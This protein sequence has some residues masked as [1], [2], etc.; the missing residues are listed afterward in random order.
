MLSSRVHCIWLIPHFLYFLP[1]GTMTSFPSS[2]LRL[3][4]SVLSRRTAIKSFGAGVAGLT[5]Y[6]ALPQRWEHP[7]IEQIILPVHAQTSGFTLS[8]PCEVSLLAGTTES[9]TVRIR[10]E[11]FVAPPTGSLAT[12]IEAV[13]QGKGEPTSLETTTAADG[14]FSGE[15]L[16]IGG[17]GITAVSVTT[18]VQGA[19]GQ[20]QC[21]LSVN[22][23][24]PEPKPPEPLVTMRDEQSILTCEF[25]SRG[26]PLEMGPYYFDF[27]IEM[28][29][30]SENLGRVIIDPSSLM[31]RR[32][33]LDSGG[34]WIE[35]KFTPRTGSYCD[36]NRTFV[37]DFAD[38]VTTGGE[39]L[40]SLTNETSFEFMLD[41]G[42]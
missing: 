35:F 23:P 16:I 41:S 26:R 36:Q 14:T 11:G 20:A 2:K 33:K 8:D 28:E 5:A 15:L 3:E 27:A 9:D 42:A 34:R 10:V 24:K 37:I 6:F 12:L 21:A 22:K 32:L 1:E 25:S 18:T 39:T 13:S 29:S 30:T 7:I 17:P 31:T 40:G 19:T 4:N 38:M